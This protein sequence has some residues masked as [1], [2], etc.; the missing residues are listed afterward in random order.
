[1]EPHGAA[2]APEGVGGVN[3]W[4]RV[5][6]AAVTASAVAGWVV[7][8]LVVADRAWEAPARIA[9]TVTAAALLVAVLTALPLRK[10]EDLGEH[11]GA[12]AV[13]L[14]LVWS[15]AASTAWSTHALREW[16]YSPTKVRATVTACRRDGTVV[17]PDV[18]SSQ[19]VYSCVY[20]WSVDG[21]SH[22]QRRDAARRY[23]DGTVSSVH[24]DPSGAAHSHSVTNVV[25]AL[26]AAAVSGGLLLF[27]LGALAVDRRDRRRED[28]RRAR[29]EDRRGGG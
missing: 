11:L 14:A 3:R 25:F 15:C 1:M 24:V 10:G 23:S 18:G 16:G 2:W 12:S 29:R 17:N 6:V 7:L 22:Q 21:R 8:W 19:D 13:A 5:S 4:Q 20:H 28:R 9:L 27:G 26:L